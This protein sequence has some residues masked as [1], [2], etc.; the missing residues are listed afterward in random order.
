MQYAVGRLSATAQ[1]VE[2]VQTSTEGRGAERLKPGGGG[3]R[4]RESGDG[5]AGRDELGDDGGAGLTG[6]AGNKDMRDLS[7]PVTAVTG[8]T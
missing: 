1:A 2:V 4:T 3:G 5:V 7:L 6:A 8:A